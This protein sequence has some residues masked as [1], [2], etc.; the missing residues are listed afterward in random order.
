MKVKLEDEII[1]YA[2]LGI[3]QVTNSM[4]W[5]KQNKYNLNV[6]EERTEEHESD[7]KSLV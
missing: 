2:V 6:H 3:T 5:K 4:P 1:P 7:Y